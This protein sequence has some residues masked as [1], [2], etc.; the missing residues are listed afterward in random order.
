M[1]G[2]DRQTEE[3]PKSELNAAIDF[4]PSKL[5]PF[6]DLNIMGFFP[7]AL[8]LVSKVLNHFGVT[9]GLF[10]LIRGHSSRFVLFCYFEDFSL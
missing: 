10:Q 3:G 7:S 6:C 8:E 5:P 1:V 2:T 4:H 9:A